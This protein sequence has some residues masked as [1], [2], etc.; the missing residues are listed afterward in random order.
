[1]FIWGLEYKHTD[2]NG[3]EINVTYN[4]LYDANKNKIGPNALINELLENET[5]KSMIE[6][7]VSADDRKQYKDYINNNINDAIDSTYLGGKGLY[8][9]LIEQGKQKRAKREAEYEEK[10][11]L[12]NI[13]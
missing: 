1:M 10:Y 11:N 9:K 12:A 2:G 5:I 13:L 7:I 3:E 4:D 6:D 8:K